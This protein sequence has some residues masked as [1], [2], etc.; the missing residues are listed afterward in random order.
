MLYDDYKRMIF[1]VAEH[2]L[3]NYGDLTSWDGDL[4]DLLNAS[5]YNGLDYFV[6]RI[7][8]NGDVDVNGIHGPLCI[9]L[10][11]KHFWCAVNLVQY[12]HTDLNALGSRGQP[13]YFGKGC[14][15]GMNFV[16]K[17]LVVD[18]RFNIMARDEYGE[19]LISQ[20]LSYDAYDL[21]LV[22]WFLEDGR[23]NPNEM[24][25]MGRTPF[26]TVLLLILAHGHNPATRAI[27]SDI[28]CALLRDRRVSLSTSGVSPDPILSLRSNGLLSPQLHAAFQDKVRERVVD[29]CIGLKGL[30]LPVLQVL[31]IVDM[32]SVQ[33]HYAHSLPIMHKTWAWAKKVK[34]T[35]V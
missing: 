30:N 4:Q 23:L 24:D 26:V 9:A 5:C 28:A 12:R 20:C 14:E 10:D 8:E 35:N 19:N 33:S 18:P 32:D 6:E 11:R 29:I 21:E 1:D 31:R 7:L 34:Q 13:I 17:Y 2:L 3:A 22:K 15:M 27:L 16:L 25:S